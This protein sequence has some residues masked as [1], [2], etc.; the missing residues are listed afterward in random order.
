MNFIVRWFGEG[1]GG[2]LWVDKLGGEGGDEAGFG[3]IAGFDG[4]EELGGGG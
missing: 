2:D 3:E 1:E 4:C